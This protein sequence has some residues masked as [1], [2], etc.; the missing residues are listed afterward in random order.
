MGNWLQKK[1]H[2][3]H[4]EKQKR[5]EREWYTDVEVLGTIRI[6]ARH[7]GRNFRA[8]ERVGID[9]TMRD[10]TRDNKRTTREERHPDYSRL[11]FKTFIQDF[12]WTG[13]GNRNR[14]SAD[15]VCRKRWRVL[16]K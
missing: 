7:F 3:K 2:R 16:F 13:G 14:V 4:T 15:V 10:N 11:S 12:H 6:H 9:N 1:E 8:Q 5:R